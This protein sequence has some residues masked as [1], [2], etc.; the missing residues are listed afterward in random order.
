MREHFDDGR[1]FPILIMLRTILW[2]QII[3]S[4]QLLER[5][6]NK[7]R[8]RSAGTTRK[9]STYFTFF[10]RVI[11]Q[12]ET[13]RNSQNG[14]ILKCRFIWFSWMERFCFPFKLDFSS[15]SSECGPCI[16]NACVFFFRE[17]SRVDSLHYRPPT[18]VKHT[19]HISSSM[20]VLSGNKSRR[21][22]TK[23]SLCEAAGASN[24]TLYL[25]HTVWTKTH[26][27][28][29][30]QLAWGILN[31]FISFRARPYNVRRQ[32]DSDY[33]RKPR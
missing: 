24:Q 3:R 32:R 27:W 8:R 15:I 7:W 17:R 2:M 33:G 23:R 11:F 14:M 20:A 31:S 6:V 13:V 16:I 18:T 12:T 1:F 9:I 5:K 10:L 29:I 28:N 19:R 21:F 4:G 25:W 22:W 30:T 26:F